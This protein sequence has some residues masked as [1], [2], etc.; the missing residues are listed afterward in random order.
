MSG[1]NVNRIKSMV[2]MLTSAAT[3]LAGVMVSA[4]LNSGSP[5]VG[6]SYEMDTIASVIIGGASLGRR[7]R[8]DPGNSGR[9]CVHGR[10]DE[11]HDIAGSQ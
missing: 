7:G 3:G 10:A 8:N 6:T 4:Q 2:F 5:N 1:L 9:L 11:F